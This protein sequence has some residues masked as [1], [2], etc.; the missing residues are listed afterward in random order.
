[1]PRTLKGEIMMFSAINVARERGDEQ[2][3]YVQHGR[4]LMEA[5][6]RLILSG[7][8]LQAVPV[9]DCYADGRYI[10]QITPVVEGG[11][12]AM[13][14]HGVGVRALTLA[15]CARWLTELHLARERREAI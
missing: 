3:R 6:D 4:T 9:V 10:G 12:E 14:A 2:G 1:M 5:L 15:D 8:L 7:S 13:P 11:W